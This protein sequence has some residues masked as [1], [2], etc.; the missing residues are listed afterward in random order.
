MYGKNEGS[1]FNGYF[2]Q[3][4][5]HPLFCFTS[6]GDLLNARLRPGYGIQP[7]ASG[8]GAKRKR[9]YYSCVVIFPQSGFFFKTLSGDIA[10]GKIMGGFALIYTL[11]YDE[12]G[13]ET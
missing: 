2:V 1:A 9:L 6:N 7:M 12:K 4:C 11:A 8:G 3:V 13:R 5:Y 10:C